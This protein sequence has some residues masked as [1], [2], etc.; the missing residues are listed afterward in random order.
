MS[1]TINPYGDGH[2]SDRI[3]RHVAAYLG[4]ELAAT[5]DA[6]SIA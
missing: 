6:P 2:A 5:R 3:A 1:R 4:V